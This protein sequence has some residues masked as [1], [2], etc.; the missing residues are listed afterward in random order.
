MKKGY[1]YFLFL[2]ILSWGQGVYSQVINQHT[3]KR[4]LDPVII[5][6]SSLRHF[7]GKKISNLRVY[8]YQDEQ[9]KVIPYQIDEKNKNGDYVFFPYLEGGIFDE[10]D[11]LVFLSKD[12]GDKITSTFFPPGFEIFS[13]INIFD[14]VKEESEWVYVFYFP[15]N[16]PPESLVDY[17]NFLPS[18]EKIIAQMYEVGF[19][20]DIPMVMT[21]LSTSNAGGG[22]NENLIDKLK[23]RFWGRTFFGLTVKINENDFISETIGWIDGKVRVIRRT[24]NRAIF[25]KFIPS[26]PAISDSIFYFSHFELPFVINLNFNPKDIFTKA[27][28]RVSNECSTNQRKFYNSH[29]LSGVD[30]DGKTD[31]EEKNLDLSPYKWSAIVKNTETDK[32]AWLNQTIFQTPAKIKPSL[33]YVDDINSLDPPEN[34]PGQIGNVGYTLDNFQWIGK[35]THKFISLLYSLPKFE[36][37]DEKECLNILDNPLEFLTY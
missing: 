34:I 4:Y 36:L 27:S 22:D 1:L 29:N 17:V 8:S 5:E 18:E 16:P 23:I 15:D 13:E 14:E 24:K 25:F 19:S 26:P 37:G 11:E 2:F 12:T 6:G 9:F 28:L 10:N 7:L 32:S 33:Y 3:L 21:Y 20:K 31:E 35:G 30:I